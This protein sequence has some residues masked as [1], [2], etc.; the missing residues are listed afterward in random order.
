MIWVSSEDFS[1]SASSFVPIES[2]SFLQKMD[3][4][5]T[6]TYP[7]ASVFVFDTLVESAFSQP[8]RFVEQEKC[9]EEIMTEILSHFE[10]VYLVK[11]MS[12]IDIYPPS[13]QSSPIQTPPKAGVHSCKVFHGSDI[14]K[15][16][17]RRAK[18]ERG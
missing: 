15:K 10:R 13:Y 1:I 7:L 11:R 5:S 8:Y 14:I 12:S 16:N 4:R 2:K 9:V 18:H 17:Y 3:I 6:V